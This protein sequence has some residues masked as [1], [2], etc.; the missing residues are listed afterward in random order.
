MGQLGN[1]VHRNRTR[2]GD[3]AVVL[4][5]TAQA[6]DGVLTYVGVN[7]LGARM[8]ANPLLAWM[9]GTLGCGVALACAK[10]VASAFGII[11][12]LSAVH[13]VVAA[14]AAFYLAVAV[15]PWVALLFF[16]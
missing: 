10:L 14:L 11:L 8:E 9:I 16:G 13:R 3:V 4:F 5:L 2:F 1:A 12:H 6:L 15:L 7:Q